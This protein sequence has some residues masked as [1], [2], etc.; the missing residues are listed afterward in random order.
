MAEIWLREQ[1]PGADSESDVILYIRGPI[2]SRYWP[3]LAILPQKKQQ[4]LLNNRV[5][6]ATIKVT[7]RQTYMFWCSI[8]TQIL[9]L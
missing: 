8:Y 5:A 9:I 1:T 7:D 2:S 4:A 3:F 6:M